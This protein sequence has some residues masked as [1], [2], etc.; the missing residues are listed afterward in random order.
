MHF[1]H[2][3][4]NSFGFKEKEQSWFTK[5]RNV[6]EK[7]V[8]SEIKKNSYLIQFFR[9]DIHLSAVSPLDKP[10]HLSNFNLS[11]CFHSLLSFLCFTMKKLCISKPRRITL[12][13]A[14]TSH[15]LQNL[16]KKFIDFTTLTFCLAETH[17]YTLNFQYPGSHIK[18]LWTISLSSFVGG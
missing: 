3:K 4:G 5:T 12:N 1:N 7:C 8:N 11:V 17:I 15:W 10:W 14:E 2:S 6:Y 18:T 16:L 13:L 9:R